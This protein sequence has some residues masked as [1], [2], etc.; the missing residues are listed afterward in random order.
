M[1]KSRGKRQWL[2]MSLQWSLRFKTPPFNIYPSI[3]R[4]TISDT[5]LNIFNK[6]VPL[7]VATLNRGHPL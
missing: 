5:A 2:P 4:P 1:S 7:L 3:L 6:V